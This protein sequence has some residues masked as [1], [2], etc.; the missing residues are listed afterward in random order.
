MF[1]FEVL[2]TASLLLGFGALLNLAAFYSVSIGF[3]NLLPIPPLDGGRLFLYAAEILRRRPLSERVQE[4]GFRFGI[5][6]IV[7]LVICA[8]YND[9]LPHVTSL[10]R[11]GAS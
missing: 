10:F 9:L 6:L 11:H 4:Y 5:A 8:T 1:L 3:F 2:L 7:T